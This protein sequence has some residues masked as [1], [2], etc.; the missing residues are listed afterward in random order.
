MCASSHQHA[1]REINVGEQRNDD[2]TTQPAAAWWIFLFVCEYYT[3]V[4]IQHRGV[5]QM[6]KG[7][8]KRGR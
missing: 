7:E 3:R 4:Y 2:D 1:T 5:K 8:I 6:Y